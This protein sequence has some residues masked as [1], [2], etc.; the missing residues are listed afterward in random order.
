MGSLTDT[1]SSAPFDNLN[2][3]ELLGSPTPGPMIAEQFIST[4]HDE[5]DEC[6]RNR[7][8]KNQ[9]LIAARMMKAPV[10]RKPTPIPRQRVPL[11]YSVVPLPAI[12]VSSKKP[13]YT[14]QRFQF[15]DIIDARNHGSLWGSNLFATGKR[16][17]R[18]F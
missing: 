2:K 6:G 11:L 13:S 15:P 12:P 4:P 14:P 8:R 9:N 3:R 5:C 10:I 16:R 18:G 17:Q 1:S 7:A